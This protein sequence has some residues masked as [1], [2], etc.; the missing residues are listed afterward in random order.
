MKTDCIHL[1]SDLNELLSEFG[2]EFSELVFCEERLSGKIAFKIEFNGETRSFVYDFPFKEPIEVK[3]YEKRY[4]KLA[5]Y[6]FL[7]DI[8]KTELPWGALTGV[9][10]TKLAR[11]NAENFRDFFVNDM[12]VSKKKTELVAK[13]LKTQ[14]RFFSDNKERAHL[15]V[16]IPL[17][18]SRC[19]Y[20]SFISCEI[21]KEKRVNEYIGGLIKEID[22]AKKLFGDYKTVYVGGGTPVA[23]KT[24]DF[25]RILSAIGVFCGEYTVEA[26]R[27]DAITEEKLAV[28]K[29]FGVTRVCVNP[30]TFCDRTLSL[31]G[32]NHTARDVI[33]KFALVRSYGFSINMDLIAG[34][35]EETFSDF[36]NSLDTAISL[37]PEN[38]TVHTLCLKS[39]SKLKESVERVGGNVVSDM[40]DYAHETLSACGYDPY[41]LYRQ[42]YMAENLENTGY[43]KRGYE[44]VYNIDVME[45]TANIVACGANAISKAIRENGA[46]IARL[47]APKDIASYLKRLDEIISE[48]EKLFN[49]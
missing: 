16:S 17:C 36:K 15:F 3:R 32:R 22:C 9:R 6:D 48:K 24:E 28:M 25:E 40:I 13:I 42:K 7:S 19:S 14:D 39:G 44:C 20:C 10:P 38:I 31:I 29:R 30:Q 49:F 12:R 46:K 21:K 47:G 43:S 4:A 35:P 45:E 18:P 8:L 1:L 26:G 37:S 41:Y 34:L 2:N 5:L 11:Q 33:E 23:L 27:P